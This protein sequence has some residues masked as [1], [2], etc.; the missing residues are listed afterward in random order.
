MR[1]SNVSP[2]PKD[3]RTTFPEAGAS[4][5]QMSTNALERTDR[6]LIAA[7]VSNDF[8]R[9]LRLI[10]NRQ[11]P[12]SGCGTTALRS[13]RRIRRELIRDPASF[14]Y[15]GTNH[16]PTSRPAVLMPSDT[17][18]RLSESLRISRQLPRVV[19][20]I[21]GHVE[22]QFAGRRQQ[23]RSPVPHTPSP[24][25]RQ[26]SCCGAGGRLRPAQYSSLRS[27]WW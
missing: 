22:P 8:R 3:A 16:S 6:M 7:A 21:A 13:L 2:T 18:L 14:T 1:S 11:S 15:R 17:R 5:L 9:A 26:R 27:V 20:A 4:D 23:T 19:P 12:R 24:V 25:N 10:S